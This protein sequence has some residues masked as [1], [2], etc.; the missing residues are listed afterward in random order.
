MI[1]I[2]SNDFTLL[3]SKFKNESGLITATTLHNKHI[4]K[5]ESRQYKRDLLQMA[6]TKGL[7]WS[8]GKHP[9]HNKYGIYFNTEN[10]SKFVVEKTFDPCVLNSLNIIDLPPRL[11]KTRMNIEGHE[12]WNRK[13]EHWTDVYQLLCEYQNEG[14]I[15]LNLLPERYIDEK[16]QLISF[17]ARELII[18]YKILK[19][20]WDEMTRDLSSYIGDR[21]VM[22]EEMLWASS[23]CRFSTNAINLIDRPRA[24]LNYL[25]Q[26]YDYQSG[27]ADYPKA[28]AQFFGTHLDEWWQVSSDVL[29][30]FSRGEHIKNALE[31]TQNDDIK[32]LFT[33][34]NGLNRELKAFNMKALSRKNDK[35]RTK[36]F[37]GKMLKQYTKTL[38]PSSIEKKS[39]L[40]YLKTLE[41]E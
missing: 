1:E 31:F 18:I 2:K 33:E 5:S 26:L 23:V 12:Y 14:K 34:W 22:F 38:S 21:N 28:E 35:A 29:N 6:V 3:V 17:Q 11:M 13:K 40:Q 39:I 27:I 7:A 16:K 19:L 10:R 25:R 30:R 4:A 37:N 36:K 24:Q 32:K 41:T 8:N 9:N 15:N 20:G